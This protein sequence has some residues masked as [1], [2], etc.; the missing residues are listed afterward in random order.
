MSHCDPPL[1][2]GTINR[3]LRTMAKEELFRF[4][5][6]MIIRSI[7]T[8][9][10]KR[11]EQDTGPIRFSLQVLLDGRALML[12]PEGSRNDGITM[13]PLQPGIALLA[14]KSK[15][16]VVPVG[17]QGSQFVLGRGAK[18]IGFHRCTVAFGKP[19]RYG[20]HPKLDGANDRESFCHYLAGEIAAACAAAGNPIKVSESDSG[21]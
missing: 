21:S 16:V 5:L 9:P 15:A 10:V 2:G 14:Q 6:G 12:F 3:G 13:L 11:G 8:F 7:G 4:P 18:R 19:F 20:D 1:V 17:I